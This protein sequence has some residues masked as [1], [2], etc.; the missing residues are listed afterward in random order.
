M[1]AEGSGNAGTPPQ[2]REPRH[3]RRDGPARLQR[4]QPHRLRT[5]QPQGRRRAPR[6]ESLVEAGRSISNQVHPGPDGGARA[7]SASTARSP[8]AGGEQARA[9][10]TATRIST[11]PGTSERPRARIAAATGRRPGSAAAPGVP[12]AASTS[13]AVRAA[14][15]SRAARRRDPRLHRPDQPLSPRGGPA[16]PA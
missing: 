16:A 3:D 1:K 13:D 10:A 9:Q 11:A 12:S 2:I 8:R 6:Q 5:R 15:A 4:A 14:A 7:V